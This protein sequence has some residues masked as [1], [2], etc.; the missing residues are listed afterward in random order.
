MD[1]RLEVTYAF[2]ADSL[3]SAAERARA[4]A[5]EQTV[6]LPAGSYPE[7][8]EREVVARVGS[9]ELESDDRWKA[10]LSFDPRL[11]GGDVPQLLNLIFGN[12]SIHADVQVLHV[13][14]PE[15]LVQA[16]PGPAYGIDGFRTLVPAAA[17][18][19][20]L[21]GATKP[22]GLSVAELAKNCRDLARGGMDIIKDDHSLTDQATAPFRERVEA[23]L[24]AVAGA[25]RA[26]RPA[27]HYFPNVTAPF[28]VLPERV[29]TARGLGCRGIVVSPFLVGLDVLRWLA[30]SSGMVVLAH[31]THAGGL[32]SPSH[33]IAAPVLFGELLRILG[34]DA[35]I[36][37]NPGG[38]FVV[39]DE[40]A[41]AIV[42]RLQQPRAGVRPALPVLGG[43]VDAE[44]V[45]RW[46]ER[47]G[48]DVM[49]LVGS[50]LYAQADLE[51]A[52][53][54]LLD[55]VERCCHG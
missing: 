19:P 24:D 50:S 32:L 31:P 36:F 11:V 47:Y 41:D 2:S 27:A 4:I 22:I 10:T 12:V 16:L 3:D 48:I 9:I 54:R 13:E 39:T 49:V 33:G 46:I 45:P 40:D 51:T 42:M 7:R 35:V 1:S 25:R 21:L 43:G 15:T 8:I 18:R 26:D 37:M 38:R 17:G 29:E 55:V 44:T 6:E 23:C 28:D 53:A 52:S 30:E 14:W 5:L 34:A 20:L